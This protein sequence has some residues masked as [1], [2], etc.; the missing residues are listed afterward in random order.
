VARLG[1]CCPIFKSKSF[2]D[3]RRTGIAP[4]RMM[5]MKEMMMV[6]VIDIVGSSAD[7]VPGSGQERESL[8]STLPLIV[9]PCAADLSRM[10][11]G[12]VARSPPRVLRASSGDAAP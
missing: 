2:V 4:R 11:C 1:L 3:Y 5:K 9:T 12:S 8:C 6:A 7:D 10:A